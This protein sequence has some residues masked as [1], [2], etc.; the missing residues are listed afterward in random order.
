MSQEERVG[1]LKGKLRYAGRPLGAERLAE[2]LSW[3]INQTEATLSMLAKRGDIVER[4]DG[5]ELMR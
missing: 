4:P 2:K 5:Y 3:R 1:T